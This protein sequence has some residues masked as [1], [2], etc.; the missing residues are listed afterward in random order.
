MST[1]DILFPADE[2]AQRVRAMARDIAQG[3]KPQIV[4]PVLAGAF[5]FAADLV[6]ALVD[7]GLSL[8]I[9]FLWLRSYGDKRSGSDVRTLVGPGD[10]VRGRSVLLI[11]GVLDKGATLAR[12]SVLLREAGAVSVTTAVVVDKRLPEALLKAD[13]AAFVDVHDFIIGYG[14]DDAGMSRALPYIGKVK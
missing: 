6:R 4:V 2:I 5:V 9:E 3:P 1:H 14:M 12:A 7:E 8:P 13:H 11:D 10:A